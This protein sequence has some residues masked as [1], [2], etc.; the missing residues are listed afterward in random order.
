MDGGKFNVCFIENIMYDIRWKTLAEMF[1]VLLCITKRVFYKIVISHATNITSKCLTLYHKSQPQ[2]LCGNIGC[3]K[4]NNESLLTC[5]RLRHRSLNFIG[6]NKV[7]LWSETWKRHILIMNDVHS[8]T[9]HLSI[10]RWLKSILN[11]TSNI[12]RNTQNARNI[13]L[14]IQRWIWSLAMHILF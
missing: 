12:H 4:C 13:P 6:I 10:N 7:E 2:Y 5:T 9:T 1:K 3:W 14:T 8:L 11:Q